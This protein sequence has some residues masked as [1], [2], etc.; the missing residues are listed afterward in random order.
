MIGL[1]QR[2][3]VS[4]CIVVSA[5]LCWS[6]EFGTLT[7]RSFRIFECRYLPVL[8]GYRFSGVGAGMVRV[9]DWGWLVRVL[10]RVSV[11][12]KTVGAGIGAGIQYPHRYPHQ[13]P[14][15]YRAGIGYVVYSI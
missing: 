15:R 8:V 4:S 9:S 5:G 13:Y 2:I 6:H 10:V 14:H 3:V 12:A 11:L 1:S 7:P